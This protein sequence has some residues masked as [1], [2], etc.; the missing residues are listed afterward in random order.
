MVPG[1]RG[2]HGGAG[3]TVRPLNDV[4]QDST[5]GVPHLRE[6]NRAWSSKRGI[7]ETVSIWWE[8]ASRQVFRGGGESGSR[9]SEQQKGSQ[10]RGEAESTHIVGRVRV[11]IE[12][13][14]RW[15][16]YVAT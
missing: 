2:V 16:R 4:V 1:D 12:P 11:A 9:A 7:D 5:G 8:K 13:R 14:F 6:S 10:A 3:R 15:G